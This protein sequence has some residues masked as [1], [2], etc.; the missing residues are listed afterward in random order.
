MP[1]VAEG[2]VL[3]DGLK[4]SKGVARSHPGLL[5]GGGHRRAAL[6]F[7]NHIKQLTKVA[8]QSTL[9]SYKDEPGSNTWMTNAQNI[10]HGGNS[11]SRLFT[12]LVSL[13]KNRAGTKSPNISKKLSRERMACTF[14][15]VNLLPRPKRSGPKPNR[16]DV[17]FAIAEKRYTRKRPALPFRPKL[18]LSE[19][20][21]T[22]PTKRNTNPS[23]TLP[24]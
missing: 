14:F 21:S 20:H 18:S 5:R 22:L 12:L 15:R 16:K 10:T 17:R 4:R 24:R 13:D 23:R 7:A 9:S 2:I 8:V 19:C 6:G 3:P 11:R 1:R